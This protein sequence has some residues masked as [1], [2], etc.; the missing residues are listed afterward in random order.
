MLQ[1]NQ[2][3]THKAKL[4][5]MSEKCIADS[6]QLNEENYSAFEYETGS[7]VVSAC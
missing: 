1:A 4:S 6:L 3:Q 2:A 5:E 7:F